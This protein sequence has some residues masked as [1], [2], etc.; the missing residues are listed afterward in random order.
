MPPALRRTSWVGSPGMA[1]FQPHEI[2]GVALTAIAAV[3]SDDLLAGRL[4]L[5]GGN[6][7]QLIYG[8]GSR[9]S[10]DL[11]FSIAEDIDP[12]L[13]RASLGRVLMERFE[14]AGFVVFDFACEPR[15]S[16]SAAKVWGG[17]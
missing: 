6:A 16:D 9:A 14:A 1:V 13:L 11:D 8:I 4:V 7:L 3:A 5:K 17:Y 10:V 12:D 2:R 15:P